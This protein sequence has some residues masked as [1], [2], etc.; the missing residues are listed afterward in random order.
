[1]QYRLEKTNKHASKEYLEEENGYVKIS[2]YL[3][4]PN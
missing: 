1:M 2:K 3:C 4:M